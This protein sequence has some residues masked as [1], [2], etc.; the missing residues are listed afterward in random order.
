MEV[1]KLSCS[2]D[3]GATLE[4]NFGATPSLLTS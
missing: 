4:R 1:E 3:E 2:D